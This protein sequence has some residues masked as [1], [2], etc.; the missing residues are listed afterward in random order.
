[1]DSWYDIFSNIGENIATIIASIK[2]VGVYTLAS[3]STMFSVLAFLFVASFVK[4]NILVK[5][6]F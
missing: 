5:V 1:M 6:E 3:F 4:S 2:T